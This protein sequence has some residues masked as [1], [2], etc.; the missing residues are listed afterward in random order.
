LPHPQGTRTWW[1]KNFIAALE[2]FTDAGRL[3]RGRFYAR[4]KKVK[5][6]EIENGRVM[7]EV[8]GSVNPYFGVYKEPLYITQIE[9]QPISPAQWTVAIAHMASKAS[10]MSKLLL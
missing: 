4:G 1:G 10:F 3:G 6:F 8:R 9:L 5:S 7:A 2:K